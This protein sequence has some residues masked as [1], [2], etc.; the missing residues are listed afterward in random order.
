M[1]L[2]ILASKLI[3]LTPVSELI[4]YTV[5]GVTTIQGV[6][7]TYE[8]LLEQP[9]WY[10]SLLSI[11][12]KLLPLVQNLIKYE[13]IQI[14]DLLTEAGNVK[15][16]DM[17]KEDIKPDRINWLVYQ[18]LIQ[19]INGLLKISEENKITNSF[20]I[21]WYDEIINKKKVI[22]S[23]YKFIM[24]SKQEGMGTINRYIKKWSKRL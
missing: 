10:N 2:W 8:E 24:N 16:L 13:I 3:I 6:S 23:V 15:S 17:V 4:V 14:K 12:G 9:I 1:S 20:E 21:I 19:A 18:G 11:S 22:S 5:A 7:P